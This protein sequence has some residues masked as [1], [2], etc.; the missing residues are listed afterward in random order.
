MNLEMLR[1]YFK[2]EK[3]PSPVCNQQPPAAQSQ[4]VLALVDCYV[5]A[6][7]DTGVPLHRPRNFLLAVL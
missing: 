6:G 4:R 1:E 5:V 2:V 3:A 7:T